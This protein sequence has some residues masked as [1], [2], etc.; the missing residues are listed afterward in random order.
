MKDIKLLKVI[1][2]ILVVLGLA[3]YYL[4]SSIEKDL[5]MLDKQFLDEGKK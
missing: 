4:A 5:I 2:A 1:S 3:T